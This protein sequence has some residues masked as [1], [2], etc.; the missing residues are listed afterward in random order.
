MV[1]ETGATP[2]R[3]SAPVLLIRDATKDAGLDVQHSLSCSEAVESDII[4]NG[5]MTLTT[6]RLLIQLLVGHS[7]VSQICDAHDVQVPRTLWSVDQIFRGN[8]NCI[9]LVAS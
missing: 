6:A 4:A 3:D 1:T 9:A 8:S 7:P 5:L 2:E